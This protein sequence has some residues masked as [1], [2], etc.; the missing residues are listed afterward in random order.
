[1]FKLIAY[2]G[3]ILSIMGQTGSTQY[4]NVTKKTKTKQTKKIAAHQNWHVTIQYY[5]YIH[6]TLVRH[7]IVTILVTDQSAAS[8]LPTN[9][10]VQCI[11]TAC[12]Q[13]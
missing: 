2:P 9:W 5:M 6:Y 12:Y 3:F 7:N 13:N 4:F 11:W 8:L 10:D 1:M